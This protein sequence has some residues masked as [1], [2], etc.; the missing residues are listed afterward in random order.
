MRLLK[1]VGCAAVG[2]AVVAIMTSVSG[3]SDANQVRQVFMALTVPSPPQQSHVR[4]VFFDD[5]LGPSS[6]GSAGA[7]LFCVVD[8]SGVNPDSTLDVTLKQTSGEQTLFDGSGTDPS[9]WQPVARQWGFF[10]TFPTT[11]TAKL[12]SFQLQTLQ[13]IATGEQLPL[14]VGQW[15]CDVA[16]NGEPAGNT[17]FT[18]I[19]PETQNGVPE[20]PIGLVESTGNPCTAFPLGVAPTCPSAADYNNATAC[21]CEVPDGGQPAD[22]TWVC[23]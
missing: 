1:A 21:H 18:V 23:N 9:K 15:E 10:E 19:Y 22:R 6:Q 17:Q 20:C 12:I 2:S 16:V 11:G 14:P 7:G 8:W 13:D 4:T 5:V 3:C